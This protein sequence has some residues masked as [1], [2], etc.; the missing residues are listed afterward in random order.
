MIVKGMLPQW[1][2][3]DHSSGA[4]EYS[5]VKGGRQRYVLGS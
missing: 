2:I 1:L 5:R 3:K 4:G